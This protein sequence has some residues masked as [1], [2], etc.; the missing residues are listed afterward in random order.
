[1]ALRLHRRSIERVFPMEHV[2]GMEHVAWR[3]HPWC[4]AI[5][6]EAPLRESTLPGAR[7]RLSPWVL[8]PPNPAP[9]REEEEQPW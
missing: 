8:P 4:G 2:L 9:S 6:G 7:S 5:S 1:V 3:L